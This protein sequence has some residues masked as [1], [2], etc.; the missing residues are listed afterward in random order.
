MPRKNREMPV[1]DMEKTGKRIQDLVEEKGYNVKQLQKILSISSHQSIYSWYNGM[2]IPSVDNFIALSK[3]LDVR[4]D[5]IV[6]CNEEIVKRICAF[7]VKE[8]FLPIYE[9]STMYINNDLNM[10]D[11]ALYSILSG[12]S[13]DEIITLVV[14]KDDV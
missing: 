9:L 14:S 8:S 10:N 6:I 11:I 12:E 13:M 4:I 5:D 1:V 7:K 2:T 3:L